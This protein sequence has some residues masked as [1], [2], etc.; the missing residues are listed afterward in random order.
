MDER[1]KFIAEFVLFRAVTVGGIL[2]VPGVAAVGLLALLLE[3]GNQGEVF[4]DEPV[5]PRAFLTLLAYK[6]T[7]HYNSSS[8]RKHPIYLNPSL[9]TP[10]GGSIIKSDIIEI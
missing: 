1:G 10:L 7:V 4:L 9:N 8:T 3:E 6:F 5:L 2:A